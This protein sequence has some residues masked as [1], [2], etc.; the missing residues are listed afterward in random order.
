MDFC[1]ILMY[2]FGNFHLNKMYAPQIIHLNQLS[3]Y[4]L[5]LGLL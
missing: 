5:D 2:S 1:V 3:D 4:C